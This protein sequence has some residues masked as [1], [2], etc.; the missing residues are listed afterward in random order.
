MMRKLVLLLFT[1]MMGTQWVAA[2][3]AQSQMKIAAIRTAY[4][5][6]MTL[7][8][9]GK[10]P[11][12]KNYQ[13]FESVAT[14]P[15]G[16]WKTRVDFIFDNSEHFKELDLYPCQLVMARQKVGEYVQEFLFDKDGELIF[17]F[18]RSDPAGQDETTEYRYYYEKG[19]P[20]WKNEKLI[21][22]KTK[23]VIKESQQPV[24]AEDAETGIWYNRPAA[25]MK[26]AFEGL[27][28]MYD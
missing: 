2:Q 20:F 18:V 28:A 27:N 23:R 13:T 12:K 1:M 25:D 9:D 10:K 5:K 3:D 7:E 22:L 26:K 8:A 16:V 15:N 17:V 14:D 19:V 24:K 6:A 4:A 21:D 11:G